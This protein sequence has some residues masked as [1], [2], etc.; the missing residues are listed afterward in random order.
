MVI[1]IIV[2]IATAENMDVVAAS[3][4]FGI[5]EGGLSGRVQRCNDELLLAGGVR[6]R[7]YQEVTLLRRYGD[8]STVLVERVLV[9]TVYRRLLSVIA[10]DVSQTVLSTLRLLG[11]GLVRLAGAGLVL[12]G[13][14]TAR[15]GFAT[16]RFGS[17]V[18]S[19]HRRVPMV[20][21]GI[22]ST[23]G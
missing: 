12:R 16:S 8:R 6:H 15:F 10:N 14:T 7:R 4:H 9:H 20:F 11:T 22:V 3:N 5:D 2:I 17:F 19:T 13:M 1:I 23:A 18:L 21:D